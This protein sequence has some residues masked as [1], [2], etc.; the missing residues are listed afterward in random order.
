MST[1]T[2][3]FTKEE[4]YDILDGQKKIGVD[5][6][7]YKF[8]KLRDPKNLTTSNTYSVTV[9]HRVL[10]E[11]S[12]WESGG[13]YQTNGFNDYPIMLSIQS[14]IKELSSDGADIKLT[15]LFPKTLNATVEQSSNQST[16]SSA[17]QNNQTTSGSSMS[18]VNTFGIQISAG[19]F[20]ELPVGSIGLDYSHSWDHTTSQ[21]ASV[22]HSQSSNAQASSG[23]EM[24]VK[25][26]SAYSSV[27]N[28]GQT[29]D[30]F[31]G[32][33]VKWNWGQTYPW[34]IFKF[35]EVGSGSSIV[36]PE[37]VIARLLYYGKTDDDKDKNILLPPSDLSLFGLDFTMIA[38]WEI[39]FPEDIT[40]IETLVFRHNIDV[41]QGSHSKVDPG[42]GEGKASLEATLEALDKNTF[43]QEEPVDIGAYALAPMLNNQRNGTSIGFKS[44]LFDLPPTGVDTKYKIL[45]RTNDLLAT[46]KG[47]QKVMNAA[48][49]EGYAGKG[50]T[51]DI[52]FKVADLQTPYALILHHWRGNNSGNIVLTCLI[53]DDWKII[54]NVDEVEGDGASNNLDQLDLRNFNLKSANFHDYLVLGMNKVNITITPADKTVASDYTLSALAIEG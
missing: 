31:V 4:E 3:F 41:L 14:G 25:D 28:F 39:T 29:S 43:T 17:T 37:D 11:G 27:D 13:S 34:N 45:A 48:F 5:I 19:F 35:S 8:L 51:V 9:K 1:L 44:H 32:E 15:K 6:V 23:N 10:L 50:A 21:S 16:G 54:V 7:T 12:S 42:S 2:D 40:S 22:G 33:V 26:W 30:E 52:S 36:L 38:E 49:E 53:N 24:S 20:G 46:G 18:N 47:F